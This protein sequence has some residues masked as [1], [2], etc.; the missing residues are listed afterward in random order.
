MDHDPLEIDLSAALTPAQWPAGVVLLSPIDARV[1]RAVDPSYIR[2]L[3]RIAKLA[4]CA[5]DLAASA[6]KRL[7]R[8]LLIEPDGSRPTGW[9]RTHRGE[10]FL[11]H[12]P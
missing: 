4:D 10:L 5:E 11:E 3:A 8:R 6:L 9:L 2:T 1:L 7:R 12:Q